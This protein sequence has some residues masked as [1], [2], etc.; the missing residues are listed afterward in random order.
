MHVLRLS[1][2]AL[3]VDHEHDILHSTLHGIHLLT[4]ISGQLQVHDTAM[5]RHAVHS[6]PDIGSLL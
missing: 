6:L 4:M 1:M 5:R 3:A 2:Q